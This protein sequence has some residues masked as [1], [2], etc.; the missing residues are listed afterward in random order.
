[1]A[2]QQRA[3]VDDVV[4]PASYTLALCLQFPPLPAV[5][6]VGGVPTPFGG[7]QQRARRRGAGDTAGAADGGVAGRSAALA[8]DFLRALPHTNRAPICWRC[9]L[10]PSRRDDRHDQPPQAVAAD[11]RCL[12]PLPAPACLARQEQRLRALEK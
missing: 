12:L 6:V 4:L 5:G 10:S 2:T 9:A 11:T 1:M 3:L 8:G 7:N